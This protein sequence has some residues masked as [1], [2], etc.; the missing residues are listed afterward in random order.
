MEGML[1]HYGDPGLVAV[2]GSV[3][4]GLENREEFVA[5]NGLEHARAAEEAAETGAEGRDEDP[6]D[7]DVAVTVDRTTKGQQREQRAQENRGSG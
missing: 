5:G 6:N 2:G 4:K 1:T 3:R 7:D